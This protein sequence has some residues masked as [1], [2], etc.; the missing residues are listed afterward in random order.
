MKYFFSFLITATFLHSCS[1]G[2]DKASVNDSSNNIEEKQAAQTINS[3]MVPMDKLSS[4]N[5]EE[6]R[7]A[8]N[9]IFAKYGRIFKSKD[10]KELFGNQSWYKENSNFNEGQ[11]KDEDK[12]LIELIQLWESQTDVLLR[13]RADLTGNGRFDNC[14]VLYN[15]NNA[16]FA[17][18]VN[19]H[20]KVFDHYWGKEKEDSPPS[21]WTAIHASIVDIHPD[22]YREEIHIHQRLMDW[23]DPGTENLIIT[24]DTELRVTT[25]SSEDYD[26]GKLTINGDGTATLLVSNCPVHT[27]DYHLDYG[28]LVEFDETIKPE[29]PGGCAACFTES[30]MVATSLTSSEKISNLQSGDEVLTYNIENGKLSIST[31]K[32]FLT[33][34]HENL[35]KLTFDGKELE[36]TED[37]PIFVEGKGW[38]SLAP[39]K[40]MKRYASYDTVEKLAIGD[41]VIY[42]SGGSASVESIVQ[43]PGRKETYTIDS[44]ENGDA[45]IVNGI[46]VGTETRK[47]SNF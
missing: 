26:A 36:L 1:S 15:E 41:N 42:A 27:K 40:T 5:K 22:D 43:I 37:H 19:E 33:V 12:K 29:P 47:L 46:V 8:R 7:I 13:E 20:F 30:A 31:I 17:V 39:E 25:L 3:P 11:M 35:Y 16:T 24:L 23:V 9:T 44:V 38:C 28:K 4:M 18:I 45:F 10:L 21:D 6:L 34:H 32:R 14:F 2:A